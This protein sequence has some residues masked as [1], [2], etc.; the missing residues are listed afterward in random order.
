MSNA[1]ISNSLSV[2]RS[3]GRLISR[4]GSIS[5]TQSS[6]LRS[7][8]SSSHL[9]S[10][11]CIYRAQSTTTSSSSIQPR[12]DALT[13]SDG[14]VGV[15]IDFDTSSSIEGKESQIVTIRL[16]KDQVLRAESGAMM[17]MT[18]G[19]QMNTTTGGGLS[20]GFKRMLTG[21]SVFISDYTYD[22]TAGPCG[23]VALGTDFPSKIVRIPLQEYGGKIICQQGAL[24]CASHT[25][26]INIEF[27]KKFSAGFFGGEG[28]VLQGLSGTGD[29]L[30]KAG[31]A[32][33][34]KDLREGE[35]LK[36]SS[37][38]LVAF[39]DGV[40]FD[41]EQVS[42]FKNVIFG[43]EG[44]FLTTLT[45]PGAVWLQ[46][47]PPQRM[48]SEIARRVPSGG[49]IGLAVPIPGMG[50]GTGDGGGEG[51]DSTGSAST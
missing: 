39:Q 45:G 7:S 12:Q 8:T 10:I 14:V 16:E 1:L 46:G 49:G 34:R 50:G 27:T 4:R 5:R 18:D 15:P 29:V 41:V 2:V 44:L 31:G 24:L 32:L 36:I 37:G 38:C 43:G 3:S 42:G 13:S 6:Y 47:Q 25:V 30:V 17:Y 11:P 40:E 9:T 51:G 35:K 20:A 26:D 33:I 22:G 48:I 23:Y 21:Q 19:I 28:F